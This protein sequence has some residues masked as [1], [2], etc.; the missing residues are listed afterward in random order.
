MNL[1]RVRRVRALKRNKDLFLRIRKSHPH[2]MRPVATGSD[3]Q[4]VLNNLF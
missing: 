4:D 2:N 1:G 3:H